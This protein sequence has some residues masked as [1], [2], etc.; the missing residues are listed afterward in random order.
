M[1]M[2]EINHRAT[3]NTE[4]DRLTQEII[5]AAIEVHRELG[6]GLLESVY[7]SCQAYKLQC[8]NIRFET[9]VTIPVFYKG[10][11]IGPSYRADFI[12]ERSVVLEIKAIVQ[13]LPIHQAQ[14]L[15]YLKLSSCSR[16]LLIN[17][18]VPL[19]CDGIRQL[20]L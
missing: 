6:P 9:E 17:F 18:N 16:G 15:S 12:V 4:R 13:I 11:D 2:Q 3:E 10:I 7:Q 1:E 20:V 14:L 5:G 8:R 19:L